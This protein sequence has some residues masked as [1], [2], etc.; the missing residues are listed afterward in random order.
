MRMVNRALREHGFPGER[1]ILEITESVLLDISPTAERNLRALAAAG[2]GLALDDFGTGYSSLAYLKDLPVDVLKIDR[3]FAAAAGQPMPD[4]I[5]QAVGTLG[6]ATG[7]RVLAE[8][9]E[10]ASQH[11]GLRELG[12]AY[13]QGFHFGHPVDAELLRR[14]ARRHPAPAAAADQPTPRVHR[15]SHR[16]QRDRP[17]PRRPGRRPPCAREEAR[18]LTQPPAAAGSGGGSRAWSSVTCAR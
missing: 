18:W 15:H 3:S 10:T 4:A 2:V 13:G 6:H 1:L 14:P 5:V 16:H 12:C 8:G 17:D 7:V 9:I 11:T